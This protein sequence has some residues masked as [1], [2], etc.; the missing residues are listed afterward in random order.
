MHHLMVGAMASLVAIYAAATNPPPAPTRTSAIVAEANSRQHQ[1]EVCEAIGELGSRLKTHMVCM[2][3][4]EWADKRQQ[5]RLLI[6][7]SQMS[8]CI[9]GT[10][11]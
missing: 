6:D 11:C 3:K 8:W 1:G 10:N 4:Q 9:Q 2:S 5:D 7:R